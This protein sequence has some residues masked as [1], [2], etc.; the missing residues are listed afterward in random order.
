MLLLLVWYHL[1][2][3][4][5]SSNIWYLYSKRVMLIKALDGF[6]DLFGITEQS[7][8]TGLGACVFIAREG[9]RVRVPALRGG[10]GRL[11]R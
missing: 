9:V 6:Q 1:G 5:K 11:M 2:V 7:G 4:R 8:N 10:A 3:C